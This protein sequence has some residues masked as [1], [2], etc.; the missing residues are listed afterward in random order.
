M[1]AMRRLGCDPN[2]IATVFVSHLHGDHFGG[3]PFMI[4]D[5]QLYSRRATPLI[6]VGPPGLAER[7]ERAMEVLFPGS[8]R[9]A[10]RFA[11]EVVEL[12]VGRRTVV[13][14]VAVT[15]FE[16]SHPCGAPPLAL[17]IEADGKVLAYTGDIL[18]AQDRGH[19]AL[20]QRHGFLHEL[21]T[22]MHQLH[23]IGK[24]QH[25]GAHQRRIL[26][27]AV[28][29]DA[30]WT[31]ATRRLPDGPQRDAG[32]EN[33]WLG[34]L[35]ANQRVVRSFGNDLPQRTRDGF[36]RF[37]EVRLHLRMRLRHVGQHA[38]AL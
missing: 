20:P 9:A 38:D 28:T 31:R 23:G 34:N 37:L 30:G 7:L 21:T 25:S 11:T 1:I 12:E 24:R 17:R 32:R 22:A 29:G 16:V 15:G 18:E 3:L 13:G 5:A 27:Q 36:A 8:V 33:G 10:R 19:C 35:G 4:L 26:A 2:A 14:G 6:V